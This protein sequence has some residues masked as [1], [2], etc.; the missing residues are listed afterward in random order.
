MEFFN[1]IHFANNLWMLAVPCVLMVIDFATGFLNA[2]ARREVQSAKM[3]TG[4]AKK[5]GEIAALLSVKICTEGMVLPPEIMTGVSLYIVMMEL[6]SITE[7]LALIGVP[8][9]KYW[10]DKLSQAHKY[11]FPNKDDGADIERSASDDREEE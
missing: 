2:W 1:D 8:A 10:K 4:L 7:N 9:P 11:Y 5:L 6:V 3:R